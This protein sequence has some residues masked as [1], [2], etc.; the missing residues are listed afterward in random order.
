MDLEVL[1]FYGKNK[2]IDTSFTIIAH[3]KIFTGRVGIA[4]KNCIGQTIIGSANPLTLSTN[5]T[6]DP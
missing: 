4:C 5:F 6:I 3:F 1:Y 2:H